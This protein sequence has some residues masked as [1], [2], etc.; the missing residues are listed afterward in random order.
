MTSKELDREDLL[1]DFKQE[2]FV[3]KGMVYMDGNS[4]GLMSKRSEAKL[5]TLMDSW[6]T[7]GIDGWTEGNHPWF[8]LAEEMSKRIAPLVGAQGNEVMVTGSITSNI[9]QMLSTLFQPTA[10]RFAIV[11]DDLNFPSDIYAVESHLRLRGLDPAKAMRK[12]GSKDGYTLEL[13]DIIEQLTDDVAI[14][15]LPSVLYRSGQLLPMRDIAKAAHEKGILVGFDLA[16]SIGAMPHHLHDDGVDFAIWCHYK[17]MNSGPGGTG[18][19]YIHERHHQLLPGNAGWFGSDKARQFDMD[20]EFTKAQGAGA[21]QIGTPHIFSMAP[22]LGS[23]ELFEEAGIGAI[24][25]KSLQL[26]RL[27]RQLVGQQVPELTDV[28]PVQDEA[29]GGHIAFAHPEAARICKALKKAKIV[30]DFRAPNIIRLAPVAFY[31]S[32]SDVEQVADKLQHIMDN[33][34]YKKFSNERNVVA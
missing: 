16:H 21:Y 14:V 24:R 15:L 23:L 20:H 19:L 28:T 2:F 17:Y 11:V 29:R 6:K 1:A 13:T 25:Q 9:H 27:L 12:V 4:L 34:T 8:T 33:E 3:E 31:T 26:T 5:Q 30:P 7:F 32:F 10:E 18:G 22:L